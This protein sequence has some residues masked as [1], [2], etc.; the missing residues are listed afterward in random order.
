[1]P[2]PLLPVVVVALVL[3]VFGIA[4][5]VTRRRGTFIDPQSPEWRAAVEKARESLPVLRELHGSAPQPVWVK[6]A[7][8]N[9]RGEIEHVWGELQAIDAASFRATLATPLRGGAPND[10]P[11]FT[12]AWSALEDWQLQLPDGRIRGGFS[13]QAEIALARRTGQPVPGHVAAMEGRFVDT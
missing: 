2:G 10:R 4:A 11:P 9:A 5:R 1:M 7:I 13:T 12:L 3:V 8:A 6:Y